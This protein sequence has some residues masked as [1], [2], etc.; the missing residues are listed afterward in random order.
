MANRKVQQP[1]IYN[2]GILAEEARDTKRG[3][4]YKEKAL[5]LKLEVDPESNLAGN[6]QGL[7][8]A[9]YYDKQYEKAIPIFIKGLEYAERFDDVL[10]KVMI[11][12][13]LGIN[14]YKM[15]RCEEGRDSYLK[16]LEFLKSFDDPRNKAYALNGLSNSYCCL[17]DYKRAREYAEQN[18][19]LADSIDHLELLTLGYESLAYASAGE[20]HYD[21]A[22]HYFERYIHLQD[23]FENRQNK[24]VYAELEIK[25][26]T[27]QK[28]KEIVQ[29]EL[30]LSKQANLRNKIIIGAI[31]AILLLT[32]IFQYL[33]NKQKL[34][35]K[36]AEL[37]LQLEQAEAD[38]LREFDQLK[39]T[40]F[41]NISHEFRTPLTLIKTP[42]QDLIKGK[43]KGSPEKYFRIMNRNA[44]RLM[45]LINQLLDLS[46]LESGKMQLLAG[47]GNIG[48]FTRAIAFS[49]ES[50]AMRKQIDF[51]VN[52]TKQ[53]ITGFF[54]K[55]KLEKILTNLL[56][57]AF[58]FTPEEGRILIEADKKEDSYII[59][60]LDNGMGISSNQLPHIFERFYQVSDASD[61]Q[62]SSGVGLALT[63]E[64]V[65]LH[66]G[67]IT[68]ESEEDKGTVFTVLLP[69]SKN[70]FS[71]NEISD[72]PQSDFEKSEKIVPTAKEEIKAAVG[73]L[74]IFKK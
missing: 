12:I 40:F 22:F 5:Q 17:E 72:V 28:E 8:T 1:A 21:S 32:A 58:K 2:L 6:Y 38:K 56:S 37:S 30:E 31:F 24:D 33:R 27:G 44:D 18:I 36:E 70:S 55:D 13:N 39:S 47:E 10:Q 43:L 26:Q 42:L 4:E 50:L 3:I 41:A 11:H 48:K 25:F 51:Q 59:K 67:K 52:I 68:V 53:P 71:E 35:Q 57:N 20:Q 63:K 46:K 45:N 69:I 23:S 16:S 74:P 19:E 61:V 73:A 49:F 65:E 14:Y 64:L 34:K 54:D 62:A 66:H 29:K 15:G 7:A 9:Y 60:V